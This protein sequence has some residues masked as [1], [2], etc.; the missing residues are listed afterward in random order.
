MRKYTQKRRGFTLIELLVVIAII[1][2]LVAL[3]LPAVQQAREAARRSSCKNNLK[4]IGLALHNYH[5]T[6]FVFPYGAAADGSVTNVTSNGTAATAATTQFTLNTRGWVGLLPFLEQA[7]LF[8]QYDP[9]APAGG[10]VRSGASPLTFPITSASPNAFVSSRPVTALLCPSDDGNRFYTGNTVNYRIYDQANNNGHP[11]AKT[12]YDFSVRRYASWARLWVSEPRTQRRMFG[13]SSSCRFRDISDG[14][15]NTVAVAE[16]TLDVKNGVAPTWAYTKWVGGGVDFAYT[17]GINFWPCCSWLS[18]PFANTTRNSLGDW[19]A[20][21]STHPG[22]MQVCLAD[23]SVRFIS[24]NI[25]R[26]T[27]LNLAYIADGNPLG[28]F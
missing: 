9:T 8:D 15:S 23:G 3:L 19:S 25:D 21:G 18:P 20:P 14:T 26:N 16:T 5:D 11:G 6:F 27:R 7:P 24:E 17:R 12:S 28:E 22:G 4:Q 13:V 2:I 1:A 10:Y